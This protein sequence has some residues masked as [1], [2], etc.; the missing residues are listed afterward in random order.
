VF[1][2]YKHYHSKAVD[3]AARLGCTDYNKLEFLA[4]FERFRRQALRP[5]TIVSAV[6]KTGIYPIN[7]AVVL[8]KVE[9]SV[10]QL[11]LL[12]ATPS[13]PTAARSTPRTIRTF[14]RHADALLD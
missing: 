3:Q 5:E 7:I 12:Q 2:P 6:Q 1:Q 14:K 9:H 10:Q 4:D 13:P 8:D 11:Q